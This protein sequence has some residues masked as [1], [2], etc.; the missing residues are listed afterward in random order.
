[1]KALF[2][3]ALVFLC[4][5]TA[6]SAQTVGDTAFA[7]ELNSILDRDVPVVDVAHV[8]SPTVF[9]DARE[10]E[11]YNVSHIRGARFI[12]YK[13]LDLGMI[14]DL[15]KDTM[16][17]VYCSVGYRSQQVTERLI[18]AGYTNVHNLYGGIFE[19]VN[20]GNTVVDQKGRTD[21][22]HTYDRNWSKWLRKGEAVY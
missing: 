3:S 20:S 13:E 15:S 18:E 8:V 7:E 10:P 12:G 9:L 17:V 16:I 4:T 6:V 11:E 2:H 1:M 14:K 21:R 19:W 5:C 22:V